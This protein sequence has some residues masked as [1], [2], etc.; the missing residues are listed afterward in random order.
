MSLGERW[1]ASAPMFHVGGALTNTLCAIYGGASVY[2]MADFVPSE[3]VRV[4]DEERIAVVLMV[5]A[6]IQACLAAVPDVAERRYAAL[7]LIA[8]GGAPCPEPVL[9]RAVE[10][11]GCDFFHGYGMTECAGVSGLL[12]E[13]HQAALAG[14]PHLLRSVG[15]PFMGTDV[16]I[17]D[18][19]GRELPV[20]ELGEI[21]IRGPQLTRGYWKRPEESAAAFRGGWLRSGDAG[22]LYAEGYLYVEDRVKDMFISGGENVYPVEVEAVVRR[23]PA[24][25]DVAVIGVPDER[26]GEA[27]KAVVVLKP[28]AVTDE[29]SIVAFCRDRI[30]GYKRPRSVD[31]VDAL[32]RNAL[33]KVLKAT[34]RETYAAPRG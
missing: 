17:A 11:F 10:V 13:E 26:W 31:F 32:P 5:P 3:V 20:G 29:A 25:A 1:L 24:V 16:R 14:R 2:V 21:L 30:A 8:Y 18:P 33:G 4:L 34:L 9:R 23:H 19:D 7:R 6:M 27:V 22:R 15:R 28:G 12:P